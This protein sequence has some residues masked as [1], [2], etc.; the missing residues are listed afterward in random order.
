M[1]FRFSILGPLEVED[2]PGLGGP[3]PRTLLARLL[4]EPNRVVGYEELTDAVW[5]ESPPGTARHTLQ[6]YVASLRRALGH[7]RIRAE[8]GGYAVSVEPDELDLVRFEE[9]VAEGTRRR[10]AGDTEAAHLLLT[11]AL[12]L[13]R[14]SP[15]ADVAP[16]L[17]PERAR[18]DE[19]RLAAEEEQ[20]DAALALGRH[21]DLVPRLE[22]LVRRHPTRERLRRHLMLALYRSDRQAEAL[23]A[24]REARRTL[25]D[26]LGLEPSADLR[27]LQAKILRQDPELAARDE[28]GPTPIHVPAPATPLVGRRREIDEVVGLL[29]GGTRL[30]TF[31]GPGGS[32]KTRLA[33][34]TARELA[35]AFPDGVVFVALGALRDASL[36]PA[37]IVRAL[38]L[39]DATDPRGALATHLGTRS[40]LLVL[41]NFEQLT[42]AAE[43]ITGLLEAAPALKVLV[44]SRHALRV[45]GEH[46]FRVEPLALTDEAVPLFV[47]RALAAGV[48]VDAA[49]AVLELCRRVDC[50]PLGI[51]LVAARTREVSLHNLQASLPR[52]EAAVGGMRGVPDRQTSL[53]STI[54]WSYE[55]LDSE[56]RR[57][58]EA[59][60]VFAGGCTQEDALAVAGGDA[61]TIGSLADKSLVRRV[62]GRVAMLET[63][64]EYAAEKLEVSGR[65]GDVRRRHADH[66][67]ALAEAGEAVRRTPAE[68]DWWDRLDADRDNVRAAL[69]WWL[70]HEPALA[71]RLVEGAFRFWYTRGHFE[72][73]AHAYK[74][75]LDAAAVAE[76]ERARLLSYASAFEFARRRLGRARALA[77][78]SLGLRRRLGDADAI[79]R[80]LVMLGTIHVEE[81]AEDSALP[82]LDES[83]AL[84]RKVNDD[85]L[86][87]F[88]LSNLANALLSAQEL[89]RFSPVGEEA[90]EVARRVGD[91][92]AQRATLLNLGL[93]ALLADDPLGGAARFA[94]SLE[95]ARELGDPVAIVESIEA[96]AAAAAACGRAVDAARLLGAAEA[97]R[98]GS[99]LELESVS[100]VVHE[101]ALATL[102]ASLDKHELDLV[103]TAGAQ[104]ASREAA[105]EA[106]AVAD[107]L[108]AQRAV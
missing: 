48:R 43:V 61:S 78:E 12:A 32:G 7:E 96:I 64:A 29:T 17:A 76:G 18:L 40:M 47:Q 70:D 24:F 88:T 54:D 23:D 6:V 52:L 21:A 44:T 108:T 69:A 82:L 5:P 15:L 60:G 57:L 13:W 56:E 10:R 19:Q 34:Q 27:E 50:L 36:V 87:A 4:L 83:V 30:V 73:A 62:D 91:S 2:V 63:I 95:L 51:E 71:A 93:A 90:L 94:E 53:R 105:S 102:R 33:Q 66:F 3:K 9:L 72:E 35:P 107:L 67:L 31:T 46:D 84:A 79:A 49:D 14:G 68:V 75:V 1:G 103:W 11:E 26:E 80:S 92:S 42:D 86:L 101:R 58:F 85:V 106:A 98:K 100:R 89:E 16:A 74:R 37:E 28:T 55:L 25:V 65:A 104:L 81:Q 97:F 22:E 99:D 8:R 41:D 45:Y 77:E 39:E 59:L 38:G 20:I